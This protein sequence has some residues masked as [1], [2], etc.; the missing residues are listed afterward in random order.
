MFPNVY[1]LDQLNMLR[2]ELSRRSGN[3][4]SEKGNFKLFCNPLSVD[5]ETVPIEPQMEL[6][7]L[8]V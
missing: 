7:E 2:A 5:V 8:A 3:F 1:S 6:I 4:K